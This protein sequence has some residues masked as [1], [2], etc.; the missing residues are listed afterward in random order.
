[1]VKCGLGFV[2][3]FKFH[4]PFLAKWTNMDRK[5]P[6][7]NHICIEV[8]VFGKIFQQQKCYTCKNWFWFILRGIWKIIFEPWHWY[9]APLI[10]QVPLFRQGSV[11]HGVI[12][13][14][15]PEKPTGQ[16]HSYVD[17]VIP[18]TPL[19]SHGSRV[20]GVISQF[21]PENPAGHVHW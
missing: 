1:M 16:V 13:Q 8:N 14:L 3:F 5:E 4:F 2:Y 15:V 21:T 19:F 12:S 20:H 7:K 18:Q 6:R 9:E 11:V 17:P 10:E